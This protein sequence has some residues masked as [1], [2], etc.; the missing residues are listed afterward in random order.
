MEPG[1][2]LPDGL[3]AGLSE[4]RRARGFEPAR[5][6]A[7]RELGALALAGIHIGIGTHNRI[8]QFA[9]RGKILRTVGHLHRH[10]IRYREGR[11]E[12]V[13]LRHNV[14]R[15]LVERDQQEFVTPPSG[16]TDPRAAPAAE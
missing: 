11:I 9:K 2:A 13:K 5:A 3:A 16:I 1:S 14:R 15:R 4:R 7:S 8:G 10:G 12:Q 6:R